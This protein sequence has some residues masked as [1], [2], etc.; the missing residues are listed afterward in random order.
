[1]RVDADLYL[2]DAELAKSRSFLLANHDAVGLHLDVEKQLPCPLDDVEKIPAHQNFTAANREEE[3][4]G[5]GELC[6]L[7]A[8]ALGV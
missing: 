7:Q 8:Q 6:A 1:M 4:S 3:D 2:L 5:I